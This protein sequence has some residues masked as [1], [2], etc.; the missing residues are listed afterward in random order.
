MLYTS[1]TM[2][3][4]LACVWFLTIATGCKTDAA[5]PAAGSAATPTENTS[6]HPRSGK[7][8]LP[9]RR[10]ARGDTGSG[11]GH[12]PGD[13][14]RAGW[15]EMRRQRQAELDT[16]KDGIVSPEERAAGRV[17]RAETMRARLDKDGDGKLTAAELGES[18]MARRI[19]DL[20]AVDANKDGDITADELAKALETVRSRQRGPWSGG[21][22]DGSGADP[23]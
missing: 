2:K 19:E 12:D 11:A 4:S 7:I 21:S 5:Q 6:A 13:D 16:N 20:G 1:G 14:A 3:R 18:R 15:A 22:G 9:A 8:D 10:S 23:R 17:Q